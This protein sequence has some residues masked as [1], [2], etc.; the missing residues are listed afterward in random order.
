MRRQDRVASLTPA[1]YYILAVLRDRP[2]HGYGIMRDVQEVT[3]GRVRLGVG[4]LYEN[5]KRLL[6]HG[7]IE[8]AGEEDVGRAQPRKLYRIAGAGRRAL[9]RER[10]RLNSM[11]AAGRGLSAL[12]AEPDH[13]RA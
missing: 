13:G 8:R 7:L 5:L 10:G 12:R 6:D 3:D 2:R 9:D 1:A 11:V 4:T